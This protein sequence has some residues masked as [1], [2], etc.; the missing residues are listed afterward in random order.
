[1]ARKK[2]RHEFLFFSTTLTE[3]AA[4]ADAINGILQSAGFSSE[5][6]F[7]ASVWVECSGL[8]S[9]CTA[10]NTVR[11]WG[12]PYWLLVIPFPTSFWPFAREVKKREFHQQFVE[13]IRQ[14]LSHDDRFTD[15]KEPDV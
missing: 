10:F 12:V 2:D 11:I 15:V 8:R 14:G 5:V 7:S 6:R 13:A 1:M 3:E 9:S 4:V